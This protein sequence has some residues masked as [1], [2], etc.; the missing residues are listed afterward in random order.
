[1]S[2]RPRMSSLL[3]CVTSAK[4]SEARV[5]DDAIS[6]VCASRVGGLIPADSEAK[7]LRRRRFEATFQ[8]QVG[9]SLP[10]DPEDAEKEAGEHRLHAKAQQNHGGNHYVCGGVRV[11]VPESNRLP[12]PESDDK[13]DRA[14][15]KHRQPTHQSGFQVDEAKK[16]RE[17][18]ARRMESLTDGEDLG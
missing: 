17:L 12:A 2:S 4:A 8:V 10:A 3:S 11:E 9:G 15:H 16:T 6:L 13:N 1:C 7:I 18:L 5:V 14:S